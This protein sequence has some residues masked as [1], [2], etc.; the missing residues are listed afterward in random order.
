MG[1]TSTG[2]GEILQFE[3]KGKDYSAMELRSILDWDIAFQLRSVPG[4]VEV[5]THGGELK[6]Y[7]VD[8]DADRLKAF[9]I[10]LETVFRA[11]EQNNYNAGGGYIEH[12]QEQYIVRGE[13]LLSTLDDVGNIVLGATP[14][15]TPVYVKNV[16]NVRFAPMLRQGATTRDGKGEAV[17]GIA[18]MLVG[19]NSRVVS[20]A[21]QKRL[22]EIQKTLPKGVMIDTYYNRTDLVNRTIA[23]V[24]KNLFEG[25]A[26]VIF[27]LL[28]MLGNWR[29]AL[30]VAS[31]IPLSMLL[32]FTGMVST[33]TSG[34]LMSLG[35]IDFGLIVDGSVVMIENIVRHLSENKQRREYGTLQAVQDSAQEVARPVFFAVLII[36]VVYVPIL[37][38]QGV[39]GKT[40]RPM[41]ITVIFALLASLLLALTY[42]PVMASLFLGKGVSEREPRIVTWIKNKYR[43]LLERAIAFPGRIAIG[44]AALLAASIIILMSLGSEFIPRLDEGALV[45][46]SQ[47]LPSGSLS[48]SIA[49]TTLTEKVLKR[50]PEVVTVVSRTGRPEVATDPMGVESSDIYV[51][52]KPHKE[53]ESAETRDELIEK[54]DE[55]LRNEV[56]GNLFSYSQPIEMRTRELA[57]GVRSDLAI[58]L[59]GNDLNVLSEKADEIVNVVKQIPGAADVRADQTRGLPYLRFIV[60]RDQI[61]R[62]GIN[63][64]DVLGAI[65]AIGGKELGQVFENQRRFP[66]QVRFRPEDREQLDK[67][68]ELKVASPS[69]ALIP[70]SQ[71][72][73][74][75][76]EDGPVQISRSNIHRRIQIAADVRGRDLGSFVREVQQA[77]KQKVELPSGYY[78][79]WGGEFQN[80]Q[81]A[82]KRLSIAVPI[83]LLLI[84]VLLYTTF[85]EVRST[86]LIFINVPVAASGGI[87]ALALRGMP[88]SISAGVGFI[89]VSG[90]AVLNGVVLVSSL[91]RLRQQGQNAE[92]AVRE[93]ALTRL[94]P[95][96][97]TALVAGFGFIPMALATSAGAEVQRP[98]ATVVIGG[99]IT[100]TALTLFVL[101][102]FYCWDERRR[103]HKRQAAAMSR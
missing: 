12:N 22:E 103:E 86:L 32:A 15:G 30:I 14:S 4:I 28:L 16:A 53:W 17:V 25:A 79:E 97:T 78:L 49:S 6:T 10:P 41:S 81:E 83:S 92:Q 69:G 5:N 94:R 72:T 98:L 35:A 102:S 13:G 11:L 55:A 34:N 84:F 96:L 67:I 8:L 54:I 38:L 43:P 93:A 88:F 40:F 33:K 90:V 48:E 27:F 65:E 95:V 58:T 57:S 42:V 64:R 73:E 44:A 19:E 9:N 37:T 45:I 24:R 82:T 3:V 75:R 87:L 66:L 56:P 70:L 51:I 36:M 61:A 47:R 85:N 46:Q 63:A 100:S 39:E 2:L 77:I 74:I 31:V 59:Y 26:L 89:A 7:E 99:L 91:Q 52:L 1:P 80:L 18:M 76:T 23:T 60:R 71:L 20:Q 62:Y 29:A 50:F 68:G 101:P 21:V